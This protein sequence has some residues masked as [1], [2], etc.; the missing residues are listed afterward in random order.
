MRVIVVEPDELSDLARRA[1]SREVFYRQALDGCVAAT[2]AV[3]GAVW[4]QA[5][6]S[7]FRP[8]C[9]V[10]LA[11]MSFWRGPRDR[12]DHEKILQRASSSEDPLAIP[13]VNSGGDDGA[14]RAANDSVSLLMPVVAA[15]F[16][17]PAASHRRV[18]VIEVFLRPG[19]SPSLLDGYRQLLS[20]VGQIASDYEAF[21]ELA[22][23]RETA[24]DQGE[25]L[26]FS[27]HISGRLDLLAT[28]YA[29]ANEGRRFT[30]C[31][32]LSVVTTQR[33]PR[34]LAMSGVEHLQRRWR[35]TRALEH[36][37]RLTC[38]WNQPIHYTEA[39]NSCIADF[40]AEL[41]D[42]LAQFLD[43][44]QSRQVIAL[45]LYRPTTAEAGDD[46]HPRAAEPFA[47][48]IAEEFSAAAEDFS[49]DRL[50]Q[51]GSQAAPALA[52]AV[53]Y[54]SLPLPSA[55]AAVARSRWFFGAGTA[56]RSAALFTLAASLVATGIFV[57][58]DFEVAAHGKLEPTAQRR[59]FA[60]ANGL[61]DEIKVSHGQQ[62]NVGDVLI[63]LDDPALELESQRITGEMQTLQ[64]R[65]DAVRATRTER[66]IRQGESR[67]V[68]ELSSEQRQLETQL[69]SLA[70][71]KEMMRAQQEYLIVRSPLA[72]QVLTWEVHE[73]LSARP[74][75][76]G[77]LLLT[78]A[79]LESPW[80][81][82]L[83]IP[84]DRIGYIRSHQSTQADP[85]PV[86]FRTAADESTTYT[87]RLDKMSM[88]A[89][90][91]QD[92]TVDTASPMVDV[93]VALEDEDIPG[94]RPG[95][96]VRA[97]VFCGRRSLGYVLLHDA[98]ETFYRWFIF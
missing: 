53:D 8:L 36:L 74:V 94:K 46:A 12:G 9:D 21:A 33:R 4:L 44:S 52:A 89:T 24:R 20:A 73:L 85:L 91:K 79:D 88:V 63:V 39:A 75:E 69:A 6:S 19:C 45:P 71:Q 35:L 51:V 50:A 7:G 86:R 17:A 10:Q 34:L 92:E 41:Q 59:I 49:R 47:V 84:D 68:Y 55:L 64:K 16:S 96:M 13:T 18:V 48:L 97:R 60:P 95:M 40:P 82:E 70:Q 1:A 61:V 38:R 32:R 37:A 81:L 80:Q 67:A 98:W 22:R 62:V 56:I 57:P 2:G 78:I 5:G 26:E 83:Q 31:D 42:D 3:G 28:A 14:S 72:G 30:R 58:L 65:L 25:L 11:S 77:E 66:A 23:H 76:R 43:E 54:S 90:P 29:I 93:H 27:R 87:G 15:G